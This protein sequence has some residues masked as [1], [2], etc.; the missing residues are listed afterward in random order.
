MKRL[1]VVIDMQRDFIS[2]ALG[3]PEASVAAERIAERLKTLR[4]RGT[5]IVYTQDTHGEDYAKTQEGRRLP[6]AH[7]LEGSEGWQILPS[8]Y[9]PGSKIFRKSAYGSPELAAYV[10]E[11]G[12]DEVELLGV[13]TDICVISNALLIRAFSPETRV[14]VNAACCA[15]AT[16]EGH[17]N[18]LRA[19][20]VCHVDII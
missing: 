6:V 7:C 19:M 12:F 14:A 4:S 17:E 20:A 8:L 1:A 13:C 11:E 16:P 10:A 2:G 3:T 9:I 15:G 18:A 5:E